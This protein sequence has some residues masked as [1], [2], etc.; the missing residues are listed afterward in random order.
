MIII[1]DITPSYKDHMDLLLIGDENLEMIKRYIDRCIIY[2]L[3]EED[4]KSIIAIEKIDENYEIK[5]FATYPKYQNK[6]YGSKL[7]KYII[8]KYKDDNTNLILGTGENPK[9][10]NFYKSFGFTYS[11]RIENFFK[12]NYKDEI[13]EEGI[14]LKDMIYLKL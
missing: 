3:F 1:K 8:T 4:L 12:D 7:L 14:V 2:G 11:H 6:G 9:T 5:N 13:I 10:I